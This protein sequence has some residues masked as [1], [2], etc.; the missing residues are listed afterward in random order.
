MPVIKRIATYTFLYLEGFA[1][2]IRKAGVWLIQKVRL[3][4]MNY[5]DRFKYA[6]TS[7]AHLTMPSSK[8]ACDSFHGT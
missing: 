3:I 4:S 5:K 2:A 6:S 8:N 7:Q 1:E